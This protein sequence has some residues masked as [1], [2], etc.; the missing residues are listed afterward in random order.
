VP[1]SRA[2]SINPLVSLLLIGLHGLLG[3]TDVVPAWVLTLERVSAA[4]VVAFFAYG[5]LLLANATLYASLP[6]GRAAEVVAMSGRDTAFGG[7]LPYAWADVRIEDKGGQV[8]R[9]L[10]TRDERSRLWGGEAV[11]LQ[12]RRGFFNVPWVMHI[13]PN[14][15]RQSQ[16]VLRVTPTAAHALFM[17]T[18]IYLAN[19]RWDEAMATALRYITLYPDNA[20]AARHFGEVLE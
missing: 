15:E 6:Y 11:E 10:L 5:V 9:V 13:F 1:G 4:I 18:N 7:L 17:L 16:A 20:S 19:D 12:L 14:V 2:L 3:W 8:E